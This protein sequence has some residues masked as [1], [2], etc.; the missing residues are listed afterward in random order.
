MNKFEFLVIVGWLLII[1][2]LWNPI[3][4]Q[5]KYY[6]LTMQQPDG[7]QKIFIGRSA[8]S[9]RGSA[10]WISKDM[11]YHVFTGPHWLDEVSSDTFNNFKL[12][13]EKE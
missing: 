10:S 11:K 13:G 2:V 1:F 4:H 5:E 9:N 3:S 8:Q 6:K 12:K 7:T